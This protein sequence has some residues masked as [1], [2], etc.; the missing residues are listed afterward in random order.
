MTQA[1]EQDEKSSVNG[2]TEL[3]A[4]TAPMTPDDPSLQTST[5]VRLGALY[6]MV[7]GASIPD[8][9]EPMPEDELR[10]WGG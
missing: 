9:S 2:D 8:F 10:K 1:T 7:A 6:G 5:K 4:N 3:R